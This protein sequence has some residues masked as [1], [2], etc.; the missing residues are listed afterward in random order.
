MLQN[1]PSDD[2]LVKLSILK[3]LGLFIAQYFQTREAFTLNF[4]A[5]LKSLPHETI[6]FRFLGN[7]N[8]SR[9]LTVS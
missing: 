6:E 8:R 9:I 3:S 7:N 4:I 1:N 5:A 2:G